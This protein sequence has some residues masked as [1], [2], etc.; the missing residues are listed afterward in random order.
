M[1]IFGTN[2]VPF[3]RSRKNVA[4]TEHKFS[5]LIYTQ[6]PVN[7]AN[8][9]AHIG[10]HTHTHIH[11]RRNSTKKKKSQSTVRIETSPAAV[12]QTRILSQSLNA[13]TRKGKESQCSRIFSSVA[14]KPFA[15][16][17]GFPL[18]SSTT[19]SQQRAT[20]YGSSNE[21]EIQVT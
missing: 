19:H 11:T 20:I 17:T 6:R 13:T 18:L 12:L 5:W 21:S 3:H 1:L 16:P 7:T 14:T 4:C 10:S 15:S 9:R 8:A 2:V